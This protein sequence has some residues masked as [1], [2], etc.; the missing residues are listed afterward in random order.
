[1]AA[2][3]PSIAIPRMSETAS[4]SCSVV[5]DTR[6]TVPDHPS[7]RTKPPGGTEDNTGLTPDVPM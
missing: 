7:T 5:N 4:W 3:G 6:A 1:L 2:S